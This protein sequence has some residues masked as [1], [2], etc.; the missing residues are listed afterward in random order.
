V[1]TCAMPRTE[2]SRRDR[3]DDRI[4]REMRKPN[5]AT[6]RQ[7]AR[8]FPGGWRLLV[9]HGSDSRVD[10]VVV[11]VGDRRAVCSSQPAAADRRPRIRGVV[12]P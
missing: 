5:Q 11:T 2:E 7:P 12:P 4:A 8:C 9:R 6:G 10:C 3:R 1:R